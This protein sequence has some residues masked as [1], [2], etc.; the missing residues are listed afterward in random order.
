MSIK[1]GKQV[2]YRAK[3]Q[4]DQ[5]TRG[6]FAPK[7]PPPVLTWAEHM[8]AREGATFAPFSLTA[9]YDKGALIDHPKFGKGVVTAIEGPRIEVCFESGTKKLSIPT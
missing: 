8:A 9:K 5:P 3:D 4:D 6:P 2:N 7:P 1:R